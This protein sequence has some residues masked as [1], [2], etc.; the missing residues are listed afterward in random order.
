[1]AVSSHIAVRGARQHNLRGVDV[2][3]E[4]GKLTVV[5]GPS[6][7]GKS[8]LVF[9]TLYAESQRR[10]VESLDVYAR[11]YLDLLPKP[12]VESIEGLSPAIAVRQEPPHRNPRSTVGTITE[13]HDFLRL[14]YARTGHMHCPRCGRDVRAHSVQQ[15]VDAVERGTHGTRVSVRAPLARGAEVDVE[16]ELTKLRRAGFVRVVIGDAPFD[17]GDERAK[18]A[19]KR[20]RVDV[21]VDRLTLRSDIRTR[22]TDAV[23]LALRTSGGV[24]RVDLEGLEPLWFSEVPYC[25]AC[26][27]SLPPLTPR[28]FSFGTPEGACPRCEGLGV[29][30][31]FDVAAVIP[32]GARS[33]A[34]GAVAAWGPSEGAYAKARIAEV[35]HAFPA[36][37]DVPWRELDDASRTELWRGP[38]TEASVEIAAPE[39]PPKK[40]R[41]PKAPEATPKRASSRRGSEP[42]LGIVTLLERR[43]ADLAT[44]R[45]SET[46]N[47]DVLDEL[48]EELRG[49]QRTQTCSV[50]AGARL[51]PES[52]A[53]TVGGRGIG[54]LLRIDATELRAWLAGL[55]L[56]GNEREIAAPLLRELVGRVAF[57]DDVG[58]GYLS[59]GRSVETLSSGEAQRIRLATR[60]GSA[61]LGVLYVLDEPTLGLHP[62]DTDRL[63]RSIEKLRDAGNTVVVVEHDLD[64]VARA[65][66]VI[67]MGPGAGVEG[68][69]VLFSGLASALAASAES[70]TAPFLGDRQ[71]VRRSRPKVDRADAIELFGVRT[72]NLRD[73]DVA[74]PRGA[75]VAVTGV[76]GSGKSSLVVHTLL[77]LA[78]S[79][80]HR[81]RRD[82]ALREHRGLESFERVVGIDQR[83]IGRTP[84]STPATYSGAMNAM[85]DLYA[86]LP[87]ARARGYD[88]ARFSSNV[89]GGRCE[90]CRGE[91]LMRV[92][93]QLLPDVFV[94]CESCDGRRY[95]RDT[96][97]V[98]YRGLDIAEALA[99]SVNDALAV[100]EAIPAI[101]DRLSG[102]ARLGLGYLSLGQSA[103][104][105]SGGECQRLH[106]ARELGR[107]GSGRT[108]YVLDEPTTGLHA[109]DVVVLFETLDQL[110]ADGHT[111]VVIEHDMSLVAAC[112]WVI[113]LGPEGGRGGGS[114]VAEGTPHDV[115]R[116]ETHTAHALA[117]AIPAR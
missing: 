61:L 46:E 96:L 107:R 81:A 11:Q 103:T 43:R 115:A 48:E 104:T 54:E 34:S 89:K 44:A 66:R 29:E 63:M 83:P 49:Y 23:E 36:L 50:C 110:V 60:L 7:S 93:M 14:L 47:G 31:A 20:D 56:D 112:D 57:L 32:D 21:V 87:E 109:S 41:A 5:T 97:E 116:R 27:I 80:I 59:I 100:F 65:E 4:R 24:L 13:I 28:S 72:H 62:R 85:R 90:V 8:S 114:I 52:L 70:V 30:Q 73:V 86:T 99:L 84:R 3:I 79:T 2:D 22:L 26:G 35:A 6:G 17:L 25:F 18:G 1:M 82:V 71:L 64:V 16:A 95:N 102:L 33:I 53:V 106:L 75:L 19:A 51:R 39:V 78:E 42:F 117:R 92:S 58:V 37:V 113:D 108:L 74:I 76:S 45:L 12:E 40:K 67:D 15:M 77:P 88:A 111:V 101:R 38:V 94:R 55:A 68:G 91:G 69:R 98:K 105:L 9:D 10:Y